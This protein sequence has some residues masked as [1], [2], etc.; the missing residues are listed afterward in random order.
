MSLNAFA[1]DWVELDRTLGEMAAS[2]SVEVR[3]DGEWLAELAALHYELRL[4]GKSALGPLWSDQRNLTRRVLRGKER[5]ENRILGEV[6]R[7]GDANPGRLE[8]LRADSPRSAGRITR[9][10]F[11]SRLRRILS[12]S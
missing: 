7:L 5:G 4:E 1:D 3:E 10:Q 12:E 11:R 9:E 8:F 6:Q 2:G